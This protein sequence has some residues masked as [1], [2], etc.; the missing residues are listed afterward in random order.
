M[1]RQFNLSPSNLNNFIDKLKQLDLE[2]VRY[3][4]NVTEKKQSRSTIQNNLMWAVLSEISNQ[5]EVSGKKF[6][7]DAWH[8]YF[9]QEY[10][11]DG[12]ESN[13]DEL[14]K[15]HETYKK[16]EYLPNGKRRLKGST[17]DLTTKGFSEYMEQIYAF[18]A[19]DGVIFN[20]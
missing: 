18:A 4:A 16:W 8:E 6:S 11:P 2:N 10:L 17:T 5:L 12:T 14:V 1:I 19:S 9:K 20:E 7:A 15:N 3:V 13:I